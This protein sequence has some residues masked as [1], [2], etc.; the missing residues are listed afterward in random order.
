M[1][2]R[3]EDLEGKLESVVRFLEPVAI[4]SEQLWE[5]VFNDILDRP[6]PHGIDL[7]EEIKSL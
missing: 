2:E 4:G 1:M 5:V 3:I 6:V 7:R